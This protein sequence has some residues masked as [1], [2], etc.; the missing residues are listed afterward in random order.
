MCIRSI[1]SVFTATGLIVLGGWSWPPD[2][3]HPPVASVGRAGRAD[4]PIASALLRL[5]HQVVRV[6]GPEARRPVEIAVAINPTNPDHVVAVS[7]QAARLGEPGSNHVY[8]SADGG[9]TWKTTAAPNPDRRSQ[10]DDAIVFG[11]DGTAHHTYIAFVGIRTPRPV[12]AA[13]GIFAN[14]SRDGLTWGKPVPIVDHLNTVEPFEDKPYLAIDTAENSPHSG[15]LYVSWTRFDV[16][17]SKDPAHKSHI[18]FARSRDGGHSFSPARRI[19]DKPGGAVDDR[20]TLMG[21]M[22]AVGPRGEVYVTWAGPEGIV[23]DQSSD[24][25]WSF[26]ADR[27][28]TNTPGGWDLQAVG[29]G[30]HNGLPVIGVDR[31]RGPHR[32]S[33]YVTWI[34]KR[35]GDPDVFLLASRDGGQTWSEPVRVNDDAQGNGKEQLFAWMVL[36]PRDGSVNIL[37][38]DRREH[39]DTRTGVTLARSVDG[40]RRFVN[41]RVNQEAFPCYPD[42]FF[43]DYIG[44]AAD[45]GRVMALYSHFTGRKQ[46]AI[47]AA[48]FRFKPGTHE[49][50][51][52]DE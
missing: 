16:Y 51:A 10:G 41:Y 19:S 27:I 29:L 46:L 26:G 50:A 1:V 8:I 25:G 5:P 12:R 7:N 42:V 45:G 37:F 33:L 48:V 24:G 11:P 3:S 23:F 18:S 38:Y 15:T 6:T 30:R 36:D 43:G 2:A 35:H 13:N 31:S 39:A 49:V 40:G 9:L 34:D 20:N 47:S 14:A 52:A 32:G 4:V 44:I 28:L 17:G 22:P 21:A